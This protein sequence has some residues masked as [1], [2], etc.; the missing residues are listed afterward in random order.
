MVCFDTANSFYTDGIN[1]SVNK[2]GANPLLVNRTY[3]T[4]AYADCSYSPLTLTPLPHFRLY[5]PDSISLAGVLLHY[6]LIRRITLE[7]PFYIRCNI[8][9]SFSRDPLPIVSSPAATACFSRPR[10]SLHT[11][12]QS[13]CS[14]FNGKHWVRPIRRLMVR[15]DLRW[16]ISQIFSDNRH[17]IERT[18][19]N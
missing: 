13:K 7:G 10:C 12:R 16:L 1:P 9:S 14:P 5:C 6:P 19:R 11:S 2:N 3:M 18:S 17:L 4:V 8:G 15:L